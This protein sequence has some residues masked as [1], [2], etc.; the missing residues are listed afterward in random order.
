MLGYRP[1]YRSIEAV[2]ES[3]S[4]LIE[5]GSFRSNAKRFDAWS[6]TAEG[7]CWR[8]DT[9]HGPT[10]MR[11]Q[12]SIRSALSRPCLALGRHLFHETGALSKSQHCLRDGVN[13]GL[14]DVLFSF[15]NRQPADS[16][17]PLTMRTGKR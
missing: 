10:A 17:A 16:V 9:T 3:V 15:V 8:P 12:C 2:Y 7:D 14:F 13:V 4:W 11:S 1:R 5:K 6:T